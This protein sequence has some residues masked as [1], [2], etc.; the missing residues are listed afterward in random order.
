MSKKIDK[1]IINSPFK[2]PKSHWKFNRAKQEFSLINE[3]RPAGFLTASQ[4]SKTFDDPGTFHE[5]PLINHI[6]ERVHNWR[7]NNY[8]G[9]TGVT[10]NLLNYWKD[11]KESEIRNFFYC[12]IEAIETLIWLT[13][14]PESEKI[15][16]DIPT[17]GGEFK[18]YCSKMATGTG[19]TV[20]MGMIVAW[21]ILNKVTNPVDSR[22]S[23]N[24][25][26]IAPGLTVKNR[27]SV[28]LP[29]DSQNYYNAF[30]IVN[31]RIWI[32]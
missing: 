30:R 18:R 24:I 13:E 28:L 23:K 6:R 8:P 15:G 22:F 29:S 16:I 11:Q 1:L 9:I 5:I 26:V 10:L 25:L 21:Q 4:D 19:K 7:Q 20:V 12:Q 14:G 2:E 31:L 17:D 32:S 3:R 27:L